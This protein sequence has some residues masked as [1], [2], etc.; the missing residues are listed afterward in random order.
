MGNKQN[1]DTKDPK[2]WEGEKRYK[3]EG[4]PLGKQG[5]AQWEPQEQR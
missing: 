3:E 5:G 4:G 2:E 1:P